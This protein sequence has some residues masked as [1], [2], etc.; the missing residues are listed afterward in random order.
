MTLLHWQRYAA[1]GE[2]GEWTRRLAEILHGDAELRGAPFEVAT[3]TATAGDVHDVVD[4]QVP[5]AIALGVDLV[6]IHTGALDLS[7]PGADATTLARELEVGVASLRASGCDVLLVT[8]SEPA[9]RASTR[10][11]GKSPAITPPSCSTCGAREARYVIRTLPAA[12]RTRS[13]CRTTKAV[14]GPQR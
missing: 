10:T 1:L 4:E 11:C 9:S 6:S 5:Q 8:S 13:G 14:V 12:P 3:V 2:T 7:R